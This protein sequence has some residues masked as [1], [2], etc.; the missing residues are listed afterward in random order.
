MGSADFCSSFGQPYSFPLAPRR[1]TFSSYTCHIY[2]SLSEW[3]LGF[4]YQRPLALNFFASY[5]VCV[6]Q[7]KVLPS[8]RGSSPFRSPEDFHLQVIHQFALA[9]WWSASRYAHYLHLLFALYMPD[10]RILARR[11]SCLDLLVQF[12]LTGAMELSIKPPA[13]VST[14]ANCFIK[15]KCQFRAKCETL[16]INWEHFIAHDINSSSQSTKNMHH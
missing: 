16:I 5:V 8:A 12:I 6:P 2:K 15:V 14:I 13:F 10:A 4:E 3:Y 7:A 11:V 9:F 1:M